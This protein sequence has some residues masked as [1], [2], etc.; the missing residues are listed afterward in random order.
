MSQKQRT[1][2]VPSR[3]AHVSALQTNLKVSNKLCFFV[4]E[5]FTHH[6]ASVW[7]GQVGLEIR[8]DIIYAVDEL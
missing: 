6:T 3:T 1:F 2:I 8:N 5:Q 4:F 7:V